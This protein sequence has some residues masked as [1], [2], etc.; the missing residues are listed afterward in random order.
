MRIIAGRHKG[1]KLPELKADGVRPTLDRVREN[2]FNIISSEVKESKF[3]DL[4]TGSGAVGYE[5]LSRGADKVV[6]CDK[7]RA[8][9]E[10]VKKIGQM[11]GVQPETFCGDYK[12][13]LSRLSGE[14]FDIVYL[15]PPYEMKEKE[16]LD[17]LYSSKVIDENSLIIYERP[18]EKSFECIK[19]YEIKDERRYGIATLSIMRIKN[20]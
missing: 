7:S 1:R 10:H 16:V 4:F 9:I 18:T 3:L 13:N 14:I 5:A 17:A 6:F 2:L 19:N 15:D 11:L 20:V 8:V 12:S